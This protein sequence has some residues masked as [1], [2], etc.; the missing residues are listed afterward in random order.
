MLLSMT[1]F[2]EARGQDD[3][4]V[5]RAEVRS[6]NNRHLK[7]TTKLSDAVAPMEPEIDRLV[8]ERVRRG[9]VQLSIRVEMPPK[10]GDYRLNKTALESYRSQLTEWLAGTPAPP[11]FLSALVGLPGVVETSRN[12]PAEET[13]PAEAWESVSKILREALDQFQASRA[14]EGKAMQAELLA[15]GRAIEGHVEK[16]AARVPEVVQGFRT[17][18]L[19]R[20][21]NLVTEFGVSIQ[22]SDL[23]R[24]VAIF[25]E[26]GDIAEEIT[27]LKAHLEQ[28]SEVVA[29]DA[30]EP[31]GRKL[32]FIVQEM[33]R[34]TNTM[35]SKSNDIAISREVV[36]IKGLM[37]KIREL[38]LNVE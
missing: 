22:P 17:R 15:M 33:G 32:E 28:Y 10:A 34:E 18:L 2:G 19:E 37:E 20:V 25:A 6:V 4:W 14:R 1:G 36:E 7:L 5:V 38:I 9:T 12:A 11:D 29:A 26:R 24:E 30:G 35:G 13:D 21:Q 27:R 23:I 3:R 8:R 16:V 31:A